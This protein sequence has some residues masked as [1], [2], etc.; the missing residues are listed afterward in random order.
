MLIWCQTHLDVSIHF[1]KR[2]CVAAGL[3]GDRVRQRAS[4]STTCTSGSP[5]SSSSARW[6]WKNGSVQSSISTVA[7]ISNGNLR[8]GE[9]VE[10]LNMEG[11]GVHASLKGMGLTGEAFEGRPI[12]GIC[13]SYSEFTHCN[14]HFQGLVKHIRR[15]VE[16]SGGLALEFPVIS[17]GSRS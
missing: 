5:M 1:L 13:N 17:L 7:Y 2:Y 8:S 12:I 4:S 3:F 14:A 9:R 6:R 16:Q 11:F 15:G 10:Q